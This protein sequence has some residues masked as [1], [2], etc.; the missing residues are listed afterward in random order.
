[1]TSDGAGMVEA[2]TMLREGR[3]V[4][5]GTLSLVGPQGWGMPARP[6]DARRVLR[7]AV[8]LGVPVIDTADAYGPGLAEELVASA[9]WP[10]G[11]VMI[12]TKGGIERRARHDWTPNGRPEHLRRACEASLRRLRMDAIPLYQLHMPDPAV[13]FLESVGALAD[14][15]REGKIGAVGLSNV[16]VDQVEAALTVTDIATVQN[17]YNIVHRESAEVVRLCEK[18]AIPFLA[19]FPLDSGSLAAAAGLARVTAPDRSITPAQVALVW[20][21]A[22]SPAIVPIP[23]TSSIEHLEANVAALSV[24]AGS[25]DYPTGDRANGHAEAGRASPAGRG[26][27]G[28]LQTQ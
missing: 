5:F 8:E 9:L 16:T 21:L 12:A 15:C 28:L 25:G 22:E 24:F 14:L 23:G 4:G 1:M 2:Q 20:L 10:Y 26:G 7:R 17:G 3:R 13:P 19:W 6:H 18:L 27:E 11:D